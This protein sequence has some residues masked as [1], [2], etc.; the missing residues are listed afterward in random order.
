VRECVPN[1]VVILSMLWLSRSLRAFVFIAT[2]WRTRSFARLHVLGRL[3]RPAVGTQATVASHCRVL[4]LLY[5]D[6]YR[7]RCYTLAHIVS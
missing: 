3:R 5:P 2:N 4:R 7:L 6:S 1:R